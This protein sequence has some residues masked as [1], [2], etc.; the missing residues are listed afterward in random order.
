M[1]NRPSSYFGFGVALEQDSI[2]YDGEAPEG[3]P[4]R[5]L[6]DGEVDASGVSVVASGYCDEPYPLVLVNNSVSVSGDWEPKAIATEAAV[7]QP[8]WADAIN[9]YLDRWELRGC[10]RKGFEKPGFLHAPYYG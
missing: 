1:G 5:L 8:G 4:S 10:V 3:S 6:S 7:E 2:E 9:A